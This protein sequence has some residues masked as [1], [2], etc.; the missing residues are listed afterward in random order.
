MIRYAKRVLTNLTYYILVHKLHGMRYYSMTENGSS[1]LSEFHIGT[2]Y[3]DINNYFR[4]GYTEI[5]K[6][7]FEANMEI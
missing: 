5:S 7:E 4:A 1:E 2:L 6:E 3:N